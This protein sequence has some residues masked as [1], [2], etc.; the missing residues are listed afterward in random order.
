MIRC[1][2]VVRDSHHPGLSRPR[3]SAA[4]PAGFPPSRRGHD[5]GEAFHLVELVTIE[6][7]RIIDGNPTPSGGLSQRELAHYLRISAVQLAI[8]TFL[9]HAGG[10]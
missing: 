1:F 3:S 5:L 10:N 8:G 6:Q 7:A 9:D 4:S 2:F